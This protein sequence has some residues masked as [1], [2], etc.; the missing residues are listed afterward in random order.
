V[1]RSDSEGHG[2]S[3]ADRAAPLRFSKSLGFLFHGRT[4]PRPAGQPLRLGLL[5][6]NLVLVSLLCYA[7]LRSLSA[8]A[9][10]VDVT[11]APEPVPAESPASGPVS[12]DA[13]AQVTQASVYADL[14]EAGIRSGVVLDQVVFSARDATAQLPPAIRLQ[15]QWSGDYVAARRMLAAFLEQTPRAALEEFSAKRLAQEPSVQM[16]AVVSVWLTSPGD[17]VQ[18][19]P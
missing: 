5:A 18:P 8:G 17:R 2:G 14:V 6:V 7:G 19:M 3:R 10:S 9:N 4:L 12:G 16:K 15:I 1:K 13:A 11:K